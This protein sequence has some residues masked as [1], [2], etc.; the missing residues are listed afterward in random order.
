MDGLLPTRSISLVSGISGLGKSPLL[1]Q[2]GICL[3]S[4]TNFL[5]Q[6]VPAPVKVLYMDC[7]NNPP[8]TVSIVAT[9]AKFLGVDPEVLGFQYWNRNTV[10]EDWQVYDRMPS[11]LEKRRPDL[12]IID[13]LSALF[14][15]ETDAGECNR[16]YVF[17]R[18]CAASY[19]TSFLLVHHLRKDATKTDE[20][21]NWL[22]TTKHLQGWFESNRGTIALVNGSDVRIGIDYP[23]DQLERSRESPA[24][25]IRGFARVSGS[26]PTIRVERFVD[27]QTGLAAGYLRSLVGTPARTGFRK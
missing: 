14:A 20:K 7:E 15:A 12:V 4:G 21:R 27:P 25:I 1:Y 24:L 6:T 18:R 13:P 16:M 23:A 8:Q 5:G 22:E 11:L 17:L 9:L 10:L 2:L 19:G 3:S 26:F